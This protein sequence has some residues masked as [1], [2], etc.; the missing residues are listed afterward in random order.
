[1]VAKHRELRYQPG[2]RAMVK[3]KRERTADCFVAGFRW[4]VERPLPSTLLLGLHDAGGGLR[5]VGAAGFAEHP[6]ERGFLLAG[7]ATAA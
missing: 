5:H 3:V 4:L 7:G 1:M 2:R 6:W